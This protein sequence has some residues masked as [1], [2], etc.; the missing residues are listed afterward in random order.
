MYVAAEL[1]GGAIA[2]DDAA[3]V[4]MAPRG[5]DVETPRAITRERVEGGASS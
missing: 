1:E 5:G 3:I 2:S 4:F